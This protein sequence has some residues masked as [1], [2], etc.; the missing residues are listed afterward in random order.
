MPSL[1]RP[2]VSSIALQPSTALRLQL[3][4]RYA[5]WHDD[6]YLALLPRSLLLCVCDYL[7]CIAIADLANRSA[8]TYVDYST[9]AQVCYVLKLKS[10]NGASLD[11]RLHFKRTDA[12]G[13]QSWDYEGRLSLDHA[14]RDFLNLE[15]TGGGDANFNAL[16]GMGVGGSQLWTETIERVRVEYVW[17]SNADEPLHVRLWMGEAKGPPVLLTVAIDIS[18]FACL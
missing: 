17:P 12:R 3:A 13:Y 18:R 5:H 11:A 16:S 8:I 6:S 10:A 9:A 14:T 15:L 7:P 2:N 1:P 4:L